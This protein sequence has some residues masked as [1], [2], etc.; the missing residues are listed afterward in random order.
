MAGRII[1][2]ALAALL[3]LGWV[4]W[5][6]EQTWSRMEQLHEEFAAIESERFLLGLHAR[7]SVVRANAALLRFQLSGDADEREKFLRVTRE[8]NSRLTNLTARLTT[9]EELRLAE[10][11]KKAL[12]RYLVET[13]DLADR[14]TRGIRRDTSAQLNDVIAEKAKDVVRLAE[15][16]VLAQ[17]AAWTDFFTGSRESLAALRRLLWASVIALLAFIALSTLLIFRVIIAPLR[18]QLWKSRAVIAQQEQ[19]AS[20][21]ILAAG[22]AHE[23]RNP[24]TAIKMRLFSLKKSLPS[25]AQDSEDLVIINGEINR[26]ERIVKDTLLFARPSEPQR[27]DVPVGDILADVERLLGASLNKRGIELR[28]G[29]GVNLN[30]HLD[31]QQIEQV[32]INLAQNAADA[33][34][35]HGT[36]TL[37]ARGGAITVAERSRPA[38]IIEVADTGPGIS[39]E[40]GARIFDPFY[41]T[42]DGGTGLGLSI[43]A[44]IVQRHGG[45]IQF[46]TRP[47]LGTTF[48]LVL[49]RQPIDESPNPAD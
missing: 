38:V 40:A 43:A 18:V 36:V 29:P 17:R 24:L 34:G 5:I 15:E 14:P 22:V 20:L 8:L 11:F 21:G 27:A 30:A 37:S 42:K 4:V 45:T 49:P 25:S 12:A 41:S 35:E 7:E 23:I 16:L 9:P 32:L 33:I 28:I 44:R 26:L 47:N 31:R 39:A 1:A 10:E 3:A 6:K 19:L 48:T 13:A 2:L 46:S